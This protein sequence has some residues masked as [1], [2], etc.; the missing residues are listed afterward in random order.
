MASHDSGVDTSNDSICTNDNNS[1]STGSIDRPTSM[2]NYLQYPCFPMGM[3]T[4]RELRE[5]ER[6]AGHNS[7]S[8]SRSE[9]RS[10]HSVDEPRKR[11]PKE[12]FLSPIR[13]RSARRAHMA[14]YVCSVPNERKLRLAASVSNVELLVRLLDNGVDPD[15][16]DEHLRSPLHLAASRGKLTCFH[17]VNHLLTLDLLLVQVTKRSSKYYCFADRTRIDRTHWETLRCIWPCVRPVH[18]ISIW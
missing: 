5:L 7:P 8:H 13:L 11:N 1:S 6:D 15:A 18:T 12:V 16:S 3:P 4:S 14:P 9:P 10:L 2:K 17:E